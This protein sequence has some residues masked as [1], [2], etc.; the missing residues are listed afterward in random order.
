MALCG[1]D[2]STTAGY[3]EVFFS[4][5]PDF[6]LKGRVVG[7]GTRFFSNYRTVQLVKVIAVTCTSLLLVLPIV[8]LYILSEK[9][10]S[11]GVKI[12]VTVLFVVLF[13]L[14]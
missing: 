8:V 7:K 1:L 3:P 4:V 10:A 14:A 5:L 11:E 12:G 2:R 13:A 6:V 9:D